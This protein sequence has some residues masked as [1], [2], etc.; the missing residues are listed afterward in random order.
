M[1]KKPQ[2]E[3]AEDLLESSVTTSKEMWI[4]PRSTMRGPAGNRAWDHQQ[5]GNPNS[6]ARFLELADIALGLKRPQMSKRKHPVSSGT[7]ETGKT[8]PYSR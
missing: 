1:A 2:R 4:N 3:K 7:H 8:E 6:G 5:I